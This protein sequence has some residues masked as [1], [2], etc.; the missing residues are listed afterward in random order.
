MPA[1]VIT[2][3]SDPVAI[4]HIPISLTERYT[5][6]IYWTID[7]SSVESGEFFNI[8]SNRIEMAIFGS[9]D[10]ITHEWSDITEREKGEIL[11]ST[12]W[13]VFEI[14]SGDQDEIGNYDSPHLRHV[15]APLAKAGISILY[16]SSYF[17]DFLLVKESDFEKARNIFTHQGWQIDPSSTPSPR[18]RSLLSPLTPSQ[19]SFPTSS[20]TSPARPSSSS[21]QLTPEITVLPSPLACIGFSKSAENKFS[22]R[23]RKFLVW[24]ERCR[25]SRS[26][27]TYTGDGTESEISEM[28][29]TEEKAGGR[30]FISYTKNEDGS[31]LVT[32]IRVLKDMFRNDEDEQEYGKSSV[33]IR[34]DGELFY[35]DQDEE[36]DG[37]H[38]VSDDS[39]SYHSDTSHFHSHENP[40]RGFNGQTFTPP[41][42]TPQAEYEYSLPPTPYDKRS[43]DV[44][45]DHTH[46]HD[47][48]RSDY[49]VGEIPIK[50]SGKDVAGTGHGRKRCLQ[51][52]LRGIGDHDDHNQN[53]G[54]GAYHLDKSGLVTRFSDL[55]T[56][57]SSTRSR[58]IRMLYSSTFHTANILVEAGDVKRA[59]RLLER[60]RRSVEWK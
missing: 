24:P 51:L 10:L 22:E 18:R 56:S 25:P 54:E 3:L 49:S 7:R 8:T 2:A 20:S 41:P 27:V 53:E 12:S 38:S 60:K 52:D 21:V 28:V 37:Y 6:K 50:W 57:P 47:D 14:S 45:E 39:M 42:E 59:K 4:V 34:S 33:L 55:L 43:F 58:P 30:P 46:E 40:P 15:S 19:P 26:Q 13:R 16:Q 17:T 32:E 44:F 31:S 29:D 36:G 1:I 11:I 48:S 23:V 9:L 5:T 35:H